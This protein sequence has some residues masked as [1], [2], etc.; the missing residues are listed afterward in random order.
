MKNNAGFLIG[1]TIHFYG[2][3]MDA[4]DE[5]IICMLKPMAKQFVIYNYSQEDYEQKVINLI[6]IFGKEESTKLIQ[7]GFIKFIQCEQNIIPQP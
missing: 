1:S 7:T 2:H 5:D 6:S 3:S 4:T